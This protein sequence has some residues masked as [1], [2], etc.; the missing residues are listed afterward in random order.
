MD[1]LTYFFLSA[2]SSRL[3]YEMCYINTLEKKKKC[4]EQKSRFLKRELHGQ[5]RN[6]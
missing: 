6:K 5:A 3:L 4:S 2:L 1:N